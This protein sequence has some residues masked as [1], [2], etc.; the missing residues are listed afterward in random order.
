M[1]SPSLSFLSIKVKP[2][3]IILLF[4]VSVELGDLLFGLGVVVCGPAFLPIL[5]ILAVFVFLVVSVHVV[6]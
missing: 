1:A 5:A 4:G 6:V 2:V 3:G